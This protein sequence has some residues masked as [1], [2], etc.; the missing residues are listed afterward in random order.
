MRGERNNALLDLWSL[1]HLASGI[2]LGWLIDPFLALVILIAW[3]PFE[4]LFLGPIL[5]KWKGIDFGYETWKN[6]ISD[7]LVDA[8]GV[9]IGAYLLA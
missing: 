9:A 6:S 3:E 7:I 2:V 5:Y 8:I 1:A 4:I